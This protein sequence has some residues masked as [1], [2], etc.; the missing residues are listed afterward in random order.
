MPLTEILDNIFV[1]SLLQI[2]D[3]IF[4]VALK[5]NH[6][7]G[8]LAIFSWTLNLILMPLYYQMERAGQAGRLMHQ[9]MSAEV[10]RIKKYYKG[11]ERYFYIRTIHR[12]FGY[13]PISTVLAAGDLYLQII[14]FATVYRYLSAH[15][16]LTGPNFG[17]FDLGSPDGILF[18]IN[19]LP[20]LMTL[21]NVASAMLYATDPGKRKQAFLLAGIFLVLLYPSPAGLVLYWTFNNLFSLGR[22]LVERRLIPMLPTG[23][24]DRLMRIAHQE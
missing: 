14:V 4:A 9:K 19:V 18:G 3:A 2:Y 13:H 15:P 24:V 1:R 20:I 5:W 23:I 6:P 11:R 22:N 7:I 16:T 10:A 8:A 21:F 17:L 12:Q